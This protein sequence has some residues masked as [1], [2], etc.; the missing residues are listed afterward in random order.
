MLGPTTVFTKKQPGRIYPER[1]IRGTCS[2]GLV[3][4]ALALPLHAALSGV[5]GMLVLVGGLAMSEE[6]YHRGAYRVTPPH[7]PDDGVA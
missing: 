6:N 1:L 2:A 5:I 3:I 7:D 4:L